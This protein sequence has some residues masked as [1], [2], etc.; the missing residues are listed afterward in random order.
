MINNSLLSKEIFHWVTTT[1]VTTTTTTMNTNITTMLF[2]ST[3]KISKFRKKNEQIKLGTI[4][5]YS[6]WF[7]DSNT[8]HYTIINK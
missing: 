5:K 4:L 6:K 2:E 7:D 3:F 1:T 8:Y